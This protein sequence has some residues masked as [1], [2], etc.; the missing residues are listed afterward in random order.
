MT[1][2]EGS[3][4]GK[5]DRDLIRD[6]ARQGWTM[7]HTRRHYRGTHP[8]APGRLLIVAVST[9]DHRTEANVRALAARMLRGGQ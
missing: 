9:S 2:W 8:Q 3:D 7:Q 5:R 4:M 1:G 6:L